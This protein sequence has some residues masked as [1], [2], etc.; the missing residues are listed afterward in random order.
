MSNPT[1]VDQ[2]V[3]PVAD[4]KEH[5]LGND[6]SC[7]CKPSVFES[8][9]TGEMIAVHHDADVAQISVATIAFIH[10]AIAIGL[11]NVE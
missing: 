5:V 9:F 8:E 1:K 2:H 10:I 7:W 4:I 3:Y 11:R 6:G